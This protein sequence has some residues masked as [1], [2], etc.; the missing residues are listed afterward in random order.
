MQYN[1]NIHDEF[2]SIICQVS[3]YMVFI[4]IQKFGYILLNCKYYTLSLVISYYLYIVFIIFD[5]VDT[6]IM[7]TYNDSYVIII[8]IV[9]LSNLYRLPFYD[10]Y[11]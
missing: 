4:Y 5:N 3:N 8:E 6:D 11:F 2:Y 9:S 7:D 10:M 1:I